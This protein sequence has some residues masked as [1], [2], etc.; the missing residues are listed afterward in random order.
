MRTF[1]RRLANLLA[2]VSA[3]LSALLFLQPKMPEGMTVWLGRIAAGALSPF[4]ALGGALAALLGGLSGSPL[5][6]AAGGFGAWASGRYLRKV[7]EPNES[8]NRAF[9]GCVERLPQ[10]QYE[11]MYTERWSLNHVKPPEPRWERDVVFWTLPG[12]QRDLRCDLWLPPVTV[13]PSGIGLLYFHGSAWVYGDKDMLTRP[14]FEHLAAQGHVVMDVAYRLFPETNMEG[15][16][17]DV[18]RAIAWMK[19]N[20]ARY[21]VNPERIV[22]WGGSAGGH[23]SLLAA[24]SAEVEDLTPEELRGQD[25]RVRGVIAEYGP[26]ELIEDYYHTRQH[27]ATRRVEPTDPMKAGMPPQLSEAL[28]RRFGYDF[29]RLNLDKPADATLFVRLLGAH[30]DQNPG[31]YLRFSPLH[32]VHPAC[33]PTLLL[34]GEAD[35]LVPVQST[36]KLAR[37]LAEVHVPVAS[38]TFPQTDH[39]YDLALLKVSPVAQAAMYYKE[40]FL[41]CMR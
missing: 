6:V 19:A 3:G 27:I 39:G 28:R 18:R 32:Y 11:A 12:S 25:L 23:L 38:V 26:S 22:L 21:G 4:L 35:L 37:R 41:A 5:A 20:G 13:P 1:F 9:G 17:G 33:P 40:R 30:P 15:M 8:F 2:L 7:T 14:S 36:R 10:A 24:Y 34:H 29:E 31:A 16:Q